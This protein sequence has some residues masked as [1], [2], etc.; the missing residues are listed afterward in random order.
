[1]MADR[2]M[3]TDWARVGKLEELARFPAGIHEAGDAK[4]RHD[5]AAVVSLVLGPRVFA[6]VAASLA[7]LVL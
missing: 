5:L 4:G 6:A 7:V 3:T 2:A 1:M